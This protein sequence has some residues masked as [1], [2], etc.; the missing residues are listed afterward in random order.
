MNND[1]N[2]KIV[3]AAP[4]P[5]FVRF[6]ASAVPMVFDNSLSYYECLCALWKWMQD[7]LVDVINNNAS[8]TEHYIEL[9]NDLKEF[10]ENYF[11]NLDVQEEIN[12]KLDQM[13]EDGTLQE[14][15]TAY[16]QANVAWTFDTVTD[17]KLA[18]NLIDGS[19]AQTIGY[20]VKN[21]GGKALY[22]I[23]SITND[24][25]VD[26]ASI[27]ELD[28]DSLVAELITDE[29]NLKQFG[30][31]GDDSHND[32]SAFAK[33]LDY[34]MDHQYSVKV[35]SGTYLL[36][37]NVFQSV[38]RNSQ[39]NNLVIKGEGKSASILK[40]NNSTTGQYLSDSSVKQIYSELHFYELGFT[41]NDSDANGF[42]QYSTGPEKRYNFHD[43][44][45][46]LNNAITMIGSGNSDLNR[47]YNCSFVTTGQAII[48]NNSQSVDNEFYDCRFSTESGSIL[49]VIAGGTIHFF[50]GSFSCRSASN[51]DYVFDM[52]QTSMGSGNMGVFCNGTRFEFLNGNRFILATS[53]QTC[54]MTFNDCNMGSAPALNVPY[55]TIE[56]RANITFNRCTFIKNL[57]FSVN[58]TTT[59]TNFGSV[60]IFNGCCSTDRLYKQITAANAYCRVI[61]NDEYTIVG[62]GGRGSS[63]FDW[64]F[65][66]R[67]AAP[68]SAK[69]KIVQIKRSGEGMVVGTTE[70][71]FVLPPNAF[72]LNIRVYRPARSSGTD[73]YQLHVGNSDK[74]VVYGES[75]SGV[76]KDEFEIDTG[77][78]G[79][80]EDNTVKLWATGTATS[81]V[82]TGYAYIEYI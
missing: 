23:R 27:I 75:A 48:V 6:V 43:C 37:P 51:N 2:E 20:H 21:D 9:T 29:A 76:F 80:L 30:C 58:A 64:N 5:P 1:I 70:Y 11:A 82:T 22:K 42:Y 74:S 68:I 49:K 55:S 28:D 32:S 10:V 33:A 56:E 4:V 67:D 38:Q 46:E 53:H 71:D 59:G 57:T 16:I 44:H 3:H 77:V 18:T 52:S 62:L 50:G 72:V 66:Q 60:L 41:G 14:I 45:F 17:M 81:V 39:Y 69:S 13:A 79:F 31:Y 78:L 65:M 35:P 19:Y 15:I 54:Q 12:N 25:V 61:N 26:E 63:D 7:N 8:V 34:A 24:D 40:L 47:F 73:T 36:S